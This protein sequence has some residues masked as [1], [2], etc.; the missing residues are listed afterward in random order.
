MAKKPKL[1]TAKELCITERQYKNLAK[2]ITFVL[3][4]VEPPKFDIK[5]Y[6]DDKKS[7][8]NLGC[9]VIGNP[10]YGCGTTACF[11]GHG[12]L[13]GIRPKHSEDWC[14]Y[15]VRAFGVDMGERDG[16]TLRNMWLFLFSDAHKNSKIAACKRAAW[17][18]QNGL[19]LPAA[20]N[21][22]GSWEVPRSFKPD[23]KAINALAKS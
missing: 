15:G 14:S 4:K 22:Y 1:K 3:H 9:D 21:W 17:L 6:Y 8:S 20:T 11:C 16:T 7:D 18:L 5:S 12:P 23:W 10:K 13:A 2:L 19:P